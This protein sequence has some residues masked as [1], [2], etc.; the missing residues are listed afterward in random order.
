[1]AGKADVQYDAAVILPDQ[2][3]S[4]IKDLG[5]GAEV[6]ENASPGHGKLDLFV[7]LSFLHPFPWTFCG[8]GVCFRFPE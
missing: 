5:Y 3:A 2:I 4:K 8:K 1:M 7:S 6:L